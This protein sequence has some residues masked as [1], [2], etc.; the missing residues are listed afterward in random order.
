LIFKKQK[1]R[2]LYIFSNIAFRFFK[3]EIG[4][5]RFQRVP[6]TETKGRTHT[7]TI[8]VTVLKIESTSK[9]NLNKKDIKR[10]NTIGSGPG[11]QHRNK[12][13]S[14]VILTHTPT[15]ITVRIDMKSQ[16]QSYETALVILANR[17][18]EFNNNIKKEIF[19]NAKRKQ[20]IKGERG[21]QIRSYNFKNN[22]IINHLK[23]EHCNLKDFFKGKLTA[24]NN[25]Q[26]IKNK[27]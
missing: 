9:L 6:P 20:F 19:R 17:V 25:L 15:N 12:V 13:Q 24:W 16:R 22:Q 21:E 14:C 2:I 7:S 10:I 8:I 11:G 3:N 26:H 1:I 5:H 4:V 27:R 18:Q 23:K